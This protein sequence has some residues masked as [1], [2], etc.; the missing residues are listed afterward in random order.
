[1][2]ERARDGEAAVLVGLDLGK[3][4]FAESLSELNHL[5]HSA[6]IRPVATVRGKRAR[7]DAATFAGSGKVTEI[8]EIAEQHHAQLVIFNHELSAGQERNLEDALKVPV[9][10]RVTLILDIFAQR[11]QSHEGK[12]QV[13]LAKLERQSTRLIRGWTHLERQRGGGGFLGGPGEKQLELDRRLIGNRIKILRG[14]LA[15]MRKQRAVQRQARGRANVFKVS[16]VGYTN[17]GKST[18]FNRLANAREYA[19]DQLFAT[20]DT[21]TRR[22]HLGSGVTMVLS[23]TVG[24]IRDLPHTLVA[25]FRATLEE[26]SY[27]DLLLHVI[28]ASSPVRDEQMQEVDRVLREIGAQTVPR[29]AVYNKIDVTEQPEP[30][31]VRDRYGRIAHIRVSAATGAGLAGLREA[32]TEL[33]TLSNL[34]H[35]LDDSVACEQPIPAAAG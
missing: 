29:L 33:A 35:Y 10:D 21:K 26:A 27:A 8:G 22:V 25:A 9:I 5:A 18:L 34:S 3:S 12:L 31:V 30:G 32:L 20:L 24:F 17:A 15:Q 14:K 2:L 11:A 1:M 13:E 4:G 6:G 16:L 19:A 23:D 7:P 28:D